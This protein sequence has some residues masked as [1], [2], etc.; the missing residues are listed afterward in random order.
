MRE[1]I[2]EDFDGHA[3]LGTPIS[4]V[5]QRLRECKT[6]EERVSFVD[7]FLLRRALTS[8]SHGATLQSRPRQIE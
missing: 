6:F 7:A 8:S 5:Y 2:D 3:V 4:D 1:L